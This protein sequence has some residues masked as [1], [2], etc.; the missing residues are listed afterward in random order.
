MRPPAVCWCPSACTPSSISRSW[1]IFSG[2]P[3]PMAAKEPPTLADV[4]EDK[5]IALLTR[6]LPRSAE[7]LVAAGDDCA[8]IGAPEDSRWLLLKT[9]AVLEGIHFLANED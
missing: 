4:G 3:A 9:D 1:P 5:L 6:G 8:V 2:M 7:V